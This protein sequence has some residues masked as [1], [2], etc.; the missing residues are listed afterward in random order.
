MDVIPNLKLLLYNKKSELIGTSDNVV[1]N[2]GRVE[3]VDLL[4]NT[5]Y[6]EGEFYISWVVNG[7][8][9]S[10]IAVPT[11]KT[12]KYDTSHTLIVYFNDI[13]ED[14]LMKLKGD[15]AY[16]VWLQQGNQGSLQ[17]FLN[18]LKGERGEPFKYSDFTKEQLENL[19]GEQG[20]PF[21]Y[22][23]F[24][25]EQLDS[26]K[27]EKGEPFTYNDFTKDQ[28]EKLKGEQGEKGENA[29]DLAKKLGFEGSE[30]EWLN[31]LEGEKGEPGEDAY[32][33]A[34]KNGY[35]GTLNQ[36]LE[37]LK[38]EKG[39]SFKYSDFTKEQLES[40]KGEKGEVDYSK[41]DS[42]G[43]NI[44]DFP[45]LDTEK[46]DKP[47]FQRAINEL[48]DKGGGTLFIPKQND[49]YIFRPDI[50]PTVQK[51]YR[52][53]IKSNNIK[54][55]GIGNPIILMDGLDKEYIDSVNDISSSGR[56][57]YIQYSHL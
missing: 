36:W 1:N 46:D 26:L 24:T 41:I 33:L 13:N 39:D 32:E 35:S 57:I 3:I 25:K 19:K 38:G 48:A 15:S 37:S 47:R 20:E 52:V 31:Y 42:L 2:K 51:P 16:Q 10:K 44:T 55:Q 12:L 53:E 50:L 40:L 29:Y 18:S 28:L 7:N 43:I 23:D 5:T 45:R 49:N 9:M 54:I 6:K 4:P 21:T 34:V 8:E 17:D 14:N 56:Y 22:S 11:F 30:E 27:G